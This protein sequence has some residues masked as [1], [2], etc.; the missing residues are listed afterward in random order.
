MS[1]QQQYNHLRH[2]EEDHA[3]TMW[4]VMTFVAIV[5]AGLAFLAGVLLAHYVGW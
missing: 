1:I 5:L 4:S 3:F 2:R